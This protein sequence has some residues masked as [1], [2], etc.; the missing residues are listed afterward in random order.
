MSIIYQQGPGGGVR[1]SSPHRD[2]GTTSAVSG[3]GM[4]RQMGFGG[5]N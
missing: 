3:E 1:G 2:G 5:E 4:K